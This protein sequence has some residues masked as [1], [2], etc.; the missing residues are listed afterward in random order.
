MEP[1]DKPITL[2]SESP[3]YSRNV[4]T[5][6]RLL[7]ALR[8]AD[9]N[10]APFKKRACL[11][12]AGGA[13]AAGAIIGGAIGLDLGIKSCSDGT[14]CNFDS[15]VIAGVAIVF[16]VAG[17]IISGALTLPCLIAACIRGECKN[18]AEED[19]IQGNYQTMGFR[20]V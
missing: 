19:N 11:S 9:Q 20:N 18:V 17:G 5:T 13:V 2:I 6:S 10:V 16:A 14:K 3:N 15:D 12:I 8:S 1:S 4:T 7:T